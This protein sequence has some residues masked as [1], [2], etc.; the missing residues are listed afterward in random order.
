MKLKNKI[1][2]VILLMMFCVPAINTFNQVY[3]ASYPMPTVTRDQLTTNRGQQVT[4]EDIV[5]TGFYL[6][7]KS[8]F[9][10]NNV[11]T[12][13]GFVVRVLRYLKVNITLC[14][15]D[16]NNWNRDYWDRFY[17]ESN[18]DVPGS[19]G[20]PYGPTGFK[21]ACDN[22]VNNKQAQY[23]G[24]VEVNNSTV[25]GVHLADG[26]FISGGQ[27]AIDKLGIQNGDLL[28]TVPSGA[29]RNGHV[30][31]AYNVDGHARTLG[32][33]SAGIH[34]GDIGRFQSDKDGDTYVYRLVE[35]VIREDVKLVK[36]D[37]NGENVEGVTFRI[38]SEKLE[39]PITATTDA[40]GE[41]NFLGD[42]G[43]EIGE[44]TFEEISVPENM[45]RQ[46]DPI[47]LVVERDRENTLTITNRY[48]TGR[49]E[50]QKLDLL[51]GNVTRGDAT[52]KDAEYT[53][54]ARQDVK[55]G[56]KTI[57]T[58]G[59]EVT[60]MITDSEGYALSEELPIGDYYVRETKAPKGYEL[61]P[62]EYDVKIEYKGQDSETATI[63]SFISKD[64]PINGR[65]RVLKWE[66]KNHESSEKSPAEGAVLRMT[67]IS[68]IEKGNPI[69]YD[70]I[71]DENG[72]GEFID[73]K[74][75]AEHPDEDST[76]PYG[77]YKIEEIVEPS[78]EAL[79]DYYMQPITFE[80][81]EN[82]KL[83]PFLV[84]DEVTDSYIR[85]VKKDEVTKKVVEEEGA[86][87][88]IWDVEAG[89][90]V[91]FMEPI[92]A[93]PIT[94]LGTSDK[95]YL[96]TPDKLKAGKTYVVYEIAAP[97]GYVINPK[98]ALPS[99]KAEYGKKN[100]LEFTV[101]KPTI[102]SPVE[103]I[104]DKDV[105]LI[106]Q[107][108][109][110]DPRPMVKLKVHKTGE[111]FT[112]ISQTNAPD[113]LGESG[114]QLYEPVFTKENLPG[115]T[116]NVVAMEKV[117]NPNK[118]GNYVEAGTVVDTFTTNND[119]IG[120]S[121]ELF[122]GTYKV[123][124]I[125]APT[126]IVIDPNGV[127]YTLENDGKET[128]VKVYEKELTNVRQKLGLTFPKR[129]DE[130]KFKLGEDYDEEP[131]ATF[132]V[133]ANENIKTVKNNKEI[134]KNALVDV[135]TVKGN[136]DVTTN[137]DLPEGKYYVKEVAASFPYTINPTQIDFELRYNENKTQ[138]YN[139]LNGETFTNKTETATVTLIKVS[140]SSM[141][142]VLIDGENVDQDSIKEEMKNMLEKIQNMTKDEV[143]EYFKEN[144]IKAVPG[145]TYGIY[146]DEAC[147]KMLKIQNDVTKEYEDAKI[148]TDESG[149][150]TLE[151]IPLG[152]Y[153]V[154]EL[155]APKGYKQSTEI[156]KVVLTA[157]N[158][159]GTLYTAL[160]EDKVVDGFIKKTDMFDG[161]VVPNCI[162][163]ITDE[164]GEEILRSKTSDKGIAYI[165]ADALENG[166]KY[167]FTEIDAPEEY[168]LNTTPHPFT[169][170]IKEVDGELVWDGEIH[171]V[172][173]TRKHKELRIL[174]IDE[175]TGE[176]L[177]GCVFS[178][179]Q[180]DKDGNVKLNA[181]GT[182]SYLV[183]NAVTDE[184]GEYLI[185]KAYYGTYK[186]T[187]VQAPEGYELNEKDMEGYVFTIDKD[188]ADRIDFIITNTGD[189]A[190][191]A[192]AVVA[193]VCV[194][195]IVFVIV[196]N[197]KATK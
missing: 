44:Y 175:K 119:G 134:P 177:A 92:S 107:I 189:I 40:N 149:M 38:T 118:S 194:L 174:K 74:F 138:E 132:A 21:T 66:D 52:F 65:A 64:H 100:G 73:K 98:Y 110:E 83:Y 197:K 9:T 193:V 95:G 136:G 8:G 145:A 50:L 85:I 12:C 60:V 56:K 14:D 127:T 195:G 106:L 29:G 26:T 120:T 162:F 68:S 90:F 115:V 24:Y 169:A 61:D 67:L 86:K 28:I 78:G 19:H 42:D 13:T 59:S 79:T 167:F 166:K 183:E 11:G 94:E 91:Q 122:P 165:P 141:Q 1:L 71:L 48:Q 114:A 171:K 10:Y 45:I 135:I 27:D 104:Y 51:D 176:P 25:R 173:N 75:Q 7:H 108:T 84:V 192:I 130:V 5:N 49:I 103:L 77:T 121:K 101:N 55:Q 4:G 170:K 69:Y 81:T 187:E 182:V 185:E 191:I 124:E 2:V 153:Y 157:E 116:F 34:I 161:D 53:V 113:S 144:D 82:N 36:K 129:F 150:I 181:D 23:I 143:K 190:V 140:T 88:K 57:Y 128:P 47:T 178:I 63:P 168:D 87:F 146:L 139:I 18:W 58:A 133:Y 32:A 109:I 22:L 180:L 41:I 35:G 158:Q 76:I 72:E 99:D 96:N 112:N 164:N 186:F 188:S 172:E 148:V 6:G 105:D 97:D 30:A 131:Q 142:S 152:E 155:V 154:K 117:L 184:N 16:P 39:S 37:S 15:N 159:D 179:V 102:G 93:K 89:E 123:V 17:S 111:M 46:K 147:T 156:V 3:A 62:N 125:D 80:L 163:T 54:W 33:G 70:I 137:I 160:K 126:G 43:L 31:F 20:S 151:N 196:R